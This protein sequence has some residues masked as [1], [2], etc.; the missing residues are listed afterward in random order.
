MKQ[1]VQ[2]ARK[3]TATVVDVPAPSVRPDH[4]LVQAAASVVS[5][6]TE[7]SVMEFAGK[8]L[9]GKAQARPD[10]V[11]Q[12]LDKARREGIVSTLGAVRDRLDRP[13]TLGYSNAGTVLAVGDGVDEFRAGDRVACAGAGSAVHAEVV[14]VP[15]NLVVT[16]PE[17]VGFES[18]A[19]A[20]LGAIALHSLRLADIQLGEVVAVIGLGMVGLLAVQVARAG[21]CRI[22]GMDV[23]PERCELAEGLGCEVALTDGPRLLDRVSQLTQG[24]G[25]DK[26]II[27]AATPSNEPMELAGSIA[28]DRATVVAVGDVGMD[29]PRQLYYEKELT[30]RVSRSYG[31]GRY[32]PAYEERGHDYPIGYVRWTENRNMQAFVHLLAD[33]KLDVG[34]LITHRVPIEDSAKAYK[35]V[36]GESSVP[37][38][39]VVITYPERPDLTRRVELSPTDRARHI[40]TFQSLSVGLLGAGGFATTT[41]LPAMKKVAGIELIGVCTATGA[42]SRHAGDKFG[43]SYCTTD[44]NEIIDDPQVNTVAIATRN[45]L[46]ARQVVAGLTA[47]KHVFCEKPLSLH[48]GE[49][50]EIV[51]AHYS[52][53]KRERASTG[54]ARGERRDNAESAAPEPTAGA[55]LLMVGFNRRFAP[56]ALRLKAFVGDIREPLVLQ[57]RVNAGYLPP[58]HWV[59]DPEQGGGRIISEVCHFVDFLSFLTGAVP[60]RVLAHGLSNGSRYHDD[61]VIVT[62]EFSNGSVGSITYVASGDRQVA[63]ERVEVFGGGA[64]AI[65]DDFRRLD[66]VSDGRKKVY[67]SR[68]HRD[69]GHRHEWEALLA[70]VRSGGPPPIPFDEIVATTLATFRLVD[71]LHAGTQVDV[72]VAGFISSA[73]GPAHEEVTGPRETQ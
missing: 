10:L 47:G 28:R 16:L 18:G 17:N 50:Q 30:L 26:V 4:V 71:A 52:I 39:G 42:R 70:S 35:I 3:G 34:R 59:H 27:C 23:S 24:H 44:E 22:V 55:P 38:L 67:R 66:L 1:L 7:R 64:A 65:L 2:S 9:L 73:L 57:Y 43:F 32:D 29:V 72:D 68:L 19:F 58:D 15:R 51:T 61:N 37:P 11:R 49:L 13:L 48:E 41:L 54:N 8:G 56:M 12:V 6:G 33:D 36:A 69:K 53:Q 60:T 45:H 46:H 25:A 14:N 20:T 62:L 63:K 21:G 31:P 40:P 5:P